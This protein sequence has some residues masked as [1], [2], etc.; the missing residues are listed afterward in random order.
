MVID[1]TNEYTRGGVLYLDKSQNVA[2]LD[3]RVATYPSLASSDRKTA[4]A[5]KLVNTDQLESVDQTFASMGEELLQSL[6]SQ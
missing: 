4:Y 6:R 2:V 5:V 3:V 1:L